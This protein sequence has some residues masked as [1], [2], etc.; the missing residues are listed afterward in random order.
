MKKKDTLW[1]QF[2]G[3]ITLATLLHFTFESASPNYGALAALKS[4]ANYSEI[5]LA[6][7]N[8]VNSNNPSYNWKATSDDR[9]LQTTAS[10]ASKMGMGR[11]PTGTAAAIKEKLQRFIASVRGTGESKTQDEDETRPT[12]R[13][14]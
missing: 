11:E 2:P 12:H 1:D 14:P 3:P 4:Q 8:H 10:D 5:A 7:C 6:V 13:G 9:N